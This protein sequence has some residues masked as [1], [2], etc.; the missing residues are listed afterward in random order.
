[1]EAAK[2]KLDEAKK[3]LDDAN[4]A[5]KKYQDNA[6]DMQAL[7]SA[8]D[9]NKARLEKLKQNEQKELQSLNEKIAKDEAQNKKLSGTINGSDGYSKKELG[10]MR[11][12]DK[13]NTENQTRRERNAELISSQ[14]K[15]KIPTTGADG[16]EYRTMTLNGE[17][18]YSRN[19]QMITQ[20]EYN[21]GLGTS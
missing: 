7:K 19:N 12:I 10:N 18:Y 15:L 9:S 1:M 4:G 17:T 21:A 20:E 16:N 6:K 2:K 5:I 3:A 13:N 14:L 11:K 8:I